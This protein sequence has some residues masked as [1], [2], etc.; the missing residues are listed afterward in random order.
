[1]KGEEDEL[2]RA[3]WHGDGVMWEQGQ[4]TASKKEQHFP[5]GCGWAARSLHQSDIP[6]LLLPT[7]TATAEPPNEIL[8][9]C[10]C[11]IRVTMDMVPQTL[12]CGF[13]I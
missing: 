4:A 13:V 11:Y 10:A 8:L 6:S 1:M 5:L 2:Q 9:A 12:G 7:N 3:P